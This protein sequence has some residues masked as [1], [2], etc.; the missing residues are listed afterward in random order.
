MFVYFSF[1]LFDDVVF[2]LFPFLG[3]TDKTGINLIQFVRNTLHKNPKD[4]EM[5]LSLEKD[6]RAFIQDVEK[7]ALRFPKMS[8]YNRMLIHR[9][10]AFF[11]LDHNID[12]SASCVICTKTPK[13][14]MYVNALL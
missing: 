2:F 6:M 13:T 11:G 12:N 14:R 1:F 5:M 10:A 3:Y 4:R 7:R 8:S 9:A